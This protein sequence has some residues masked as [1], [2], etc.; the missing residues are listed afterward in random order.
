MSPRLKSINERA[1]NEII[2]IILKSWLEQR[3]RGT[4]SLMFTF[5]LCLLSA[6]DNMTKI[7]ALQRKYEPRGPLVRSQKGGQ[8]MQESGLEMG[9]AQFS[10]HSWLLSLHIL[11]ELWVLYR[12]AGLLGPESL[13]TV[14]SICNS[15]TKEHAEVGSQCEHVTGDTGVNMNL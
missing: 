10:P 2:C 14:H 13:H 5:H 7:F 4:S 3:G 9:R 11:G 15:R 6:A 12:L 1:K 8:S